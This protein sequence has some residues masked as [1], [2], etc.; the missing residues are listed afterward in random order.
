MLPP[1]SEAA[2]Y[3]HVGPAHIVQVD[4]VPYVMKLSPGVFWDIALMRTEQT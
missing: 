4:A 2:F 3:M 1:T